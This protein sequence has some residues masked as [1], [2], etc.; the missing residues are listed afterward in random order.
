[1]AIFHTIRIINKN[2][3]LSLEMRIFNPIKQGN[4][5]LMKLFCISI[6]EYQP[7]VD[8]LHIIPHEDYFPHSSLVHTHGN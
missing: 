7:S 2:K 6:L 8:I 1:M 3:T 4:I 5:F